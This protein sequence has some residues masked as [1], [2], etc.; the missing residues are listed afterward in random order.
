MKGLRYILFTWCFTIFCAVQGQ[1]ECSNALVRAN[2]IYGQG[3]LQ[4]AIDQLEGCYS[5]FTSSE[6]RFEASRLLALAYLNKDDYEIAHT[7]IRNMLE[8]RP[9][10]ARYSIGNDPKN[11]S[12]LITAYDVSPVLSM[13]IYAGTSVQSPKIKTNYNPYEQGKSKYLNSLGYSVG[14]EAIWSLNNSLQLNAN[15]YLQGG[16]IE[17]EISEID[18]LTIKYKELYDLISVSVG[19]QHR[20]H[21]STLW[22]ANVGPHL[23]FGNLFDDHMLVT[24]EYANSNEINQFSSGGLDNRLKNQFF[25]GLSVELNRKM[26]LGSLGIRWQYDHFMKPL[27]NEESRLN[28]LDF[29]L[30]SLYFNDLVKLRSHHFQLVYTFPLQY[31][32]KRD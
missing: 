3:D 18:Q 16:S 15:V 30:N 8:L 12:N 26:Q 19:A 32:I 1:V 2:T 5:N 20:Y 29:A 23:G 6:Q 31:R 14:A 25:G 11:L 4:G 22:S 28:D 13:G 21:L 17:Q 10:Y 9:N 7:H 27:I 24:H